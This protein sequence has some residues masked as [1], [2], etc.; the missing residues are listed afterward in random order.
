[1]FCRMSELISFHANEILEITAWSVH[2]FCVGVHHLSTSVVAH[3]FIGFA[4]RRIPVAIGDDL[5]GLVLCRIGI[6]TNTK[7]I[8]MN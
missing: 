4:V 1:M 8:Y 5:R 7:N 2:P 6:A 3:D